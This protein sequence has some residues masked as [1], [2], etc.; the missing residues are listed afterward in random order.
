[1][2][3]FR[4]V[5]KFL[6]FLLV[7]IAFYGNNLVTINGRQGSDDQFISYIVDLAKQ[8][9]RLY[10]KDAG[11]KDI[12]T[13]SR[14]KGI[15]EAQNKTLLFAMNGGMYMTDYAP[16]GLYIEEGKTIR[17]IN[18]KNAKGNFYTKPNGVFYLTNDNIPVVCTTGDFKPGKNIRF[19]TQSGPMLLI[20]G[21]YHPDFKKGSLN[22][23][24][25][26]GVGILPDNRVV[27]AISNTPVNFYDFATYFKKLGCKDALYLDGAVSEMYLP[28]K[29][30]T[31]NYG[32]FGVIIG[33]TEK[34]K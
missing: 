15:V 20:N 24:I 12:N 28:E 33:V 2:K 34:K 10:Y 13:F 27:F 9:L 30:L 6:L 32:S 22:L 23:N 26:N 8:D 29:G 18:R 14:L 31:S 19:A 7:C 21:K 5:F 1:M 25:R 16:L 3:T 11:G 17:K 4:G